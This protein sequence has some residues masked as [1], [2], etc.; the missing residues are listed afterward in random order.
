MSFPKHFLWGG[1][2]A[3]NQYEGGYLS[4]GKGLAITDTITGG[5]GL[6]N[7]P[8]YMTVQLADG[9]KT[10]LERGF[11]TEM[12]AGA[13][14]YV[15][16]DYYYPSHVATDFY[17]HWKEDIALLAEMGFKAFRLSINWTR[18]FPNGDDKIP[19]EEGLIFYENI[20]KECLTYG[21]EPV[22]TL[23]H[24]DCPLHLATKYGGWENRQ[25]VDF[26]TH[27][28][29]TV[30]K[31]YKGKV[32]YWMTFN[33]INFL[34]DYSMIGIT[35]E[36]SNPQRLAQAI[37]HV[38][39]A[40][41]KTVKIGHDIDSQN[42]I[43]MMVAYMLTYPQTCNPDDIWADMDVSKDLR[44]F[45]LDVQCRGYY[46]SYKLKELERQGITLLKESDD[47]QL[48]LDGIV[49]YIGFSYYNSLVTSSAPEG[50]STGGNQMGGLKNPYLE[51]TEWGWPIDPIGLRIALNRLWNTYQ[52]P[53]MIVENGLGAKDDIAEDGHIYDDYRIDYLQK[54]IIEM[55][56]A[57]SLDGVDLIGYMPWGC[58]DLVSA[59][60]G[61]MRKRYGF[62]YVDM[63]DSG[64]GS[65]N[66]IPK[67]S[68][69]W[70]KKVIETNGEILKGI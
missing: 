32:K 16:P 61:E 11:N 15:D 17:H 13:I 38:L 58:I 64:N 30:F 22:V 5:D 37:Y 63:D 59:G 62:V 69:Y 29:E 43:G 57:I 36:K 65:L 67:K 70:Y 49:D 10:K 41:A 33:E 52:K 20:F 27:Y 55:E 7:I 66:R 46:P 54:H 47:D 21:I 35:E 39:L 28:A 4:G 45:Y 48:L 51:E 34:R 12:P 1:A 68:F 56:K 23:N 53:L 42:Q 26:F 2:T 3:A 31:R 40:S 44:D 19:N 50:D 25:V 8:R 24:F 60:T 18:I 9:T 14:A 6:N